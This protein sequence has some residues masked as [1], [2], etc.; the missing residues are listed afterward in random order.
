MTIG[1]TGLLLVAG[2][3]ALGGMGR[4]ALANLVARHLGAGFPWGTL[5]VNL[6]G[7]LL[8]GLLAGVQGPPTPGGGPVWQLLAIGLSYRQALEEDPAD[9]ATRWRLGRVCAHAVE[10]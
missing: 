10:S 5:A 7:A 9:G 2:G 3:G 6:S 1:L 8:M 4:L